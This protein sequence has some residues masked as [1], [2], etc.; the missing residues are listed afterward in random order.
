MRRQLFEESNDG[1]KRFGGARLALP[2]KI[3]NCVDGFKKFYDTGS[4]RDNFAYDGCSITEAV[5]AILFNR[6]EYWSR[7]PP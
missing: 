4:T 2:C 1:P 3:Q 7:H 5:M 6:N